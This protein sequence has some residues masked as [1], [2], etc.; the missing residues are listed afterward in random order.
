MQLGEEQ[1]RGVQRSYL[2]EIV[3]KA[4][5]NNPPQLIINWYQTGLNVVPKS[6]WTMEEQG[7][8]RVEIAGLGDKRQITATFAVAMSGAVLAVQMLYAGKTPI[9]SRNNHDVNIQHSCAHMQLE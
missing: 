4:Q 5:A 1:F 6:Y 7:S 9:Y 2:V 3:Q 8:Q